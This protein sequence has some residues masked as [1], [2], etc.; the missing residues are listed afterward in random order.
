LTPY[1]LQSRPVNEQTILYILITVSGR[2]RAIKIINTLKNNNIIRHS[3][4]QHLLFSNN[5]VANELCHKNANHNEI[6]I[7]VYFANC[8]NLADIPYRFTGEQDGASP[9]HGGRDVLYNF[10]QGRCG[11]V[12][13]SYLWEIQL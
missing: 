6:A 10:H 3:D 4:N 1:H 13:H 11:G 12:G 2:Q 9:Q 5:Q 7:A 8:Y